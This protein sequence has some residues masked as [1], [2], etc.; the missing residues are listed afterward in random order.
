MAGVGGRGVIFGGVT[1]W[2][3]SQPWPKD[4]G[5]CGAAGA[6]GARAGDA[7]AAAKG[8]CRAGGAQPSAR[9]A[10]GRGALLWGPAV[11]SA[12]SLCPR[13]PVSRVLPQG[14]A[15]LQCGVRSQ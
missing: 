15:L 9:G 3:R 14:T 2:E 13:V 5:G 4:A 10:P 11:T 6:E 7:A 12:V 8:G 1:Q